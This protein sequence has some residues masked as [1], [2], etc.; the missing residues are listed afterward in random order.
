L[1]QTLLV[2]LTLAAQAAPAEHGDEARQLTLQS[3]RE[4][5]LAD[6][7]PAL[8]DAK[9]AYA[10]S[11]KP[12]LLFNLG[13]CHRALGHWKEAKFF[14]RGF[15]REQKDARN[16]REVLDLIAQMEAEEQRAP[17][18]A[19]STTT[20]AP[21]QSPAVP[22][23][24]NPT[25]ASPSLPAPAPEV[26]SPAPATAVTEESPAPRGIPS[27][28]WW[29]GG[30]GVGAVIAGTV[31]GFVAKDG[32]GT[33]QENGLTV[34]NGTTGSA[35]QTGQYEGLSADILWGVGGALVVAAVIVAV[36]AH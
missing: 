29:L 23:A 21:S 10:I 30:G 34:H 25:A 11:G 18:T 36:A 19:A 33:S 35:Y 14:Y 7:E 32:T 9:Q 31:L 26:L 8:R 13:Q 20:P 17:Q 28:T 12:A 5:N 3:I 27:G 16:R 6:F 15:L 2:V 24:A 4:Y 22:P 1:I